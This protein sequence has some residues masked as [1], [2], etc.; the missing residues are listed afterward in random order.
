MI[1]LLKVRSPLLAFVGLC[2]VGLVAMQLVQGAITVTAAAE[3]VLVVAVALS[4]VDRWVLPV[5]KA[6]VGGTRS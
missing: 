6:M 3:R 2:V 4:L 5:A 1:G